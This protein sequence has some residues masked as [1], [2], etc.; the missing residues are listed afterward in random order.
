MEGG[1]LTEK[2]WGVV[3]MTLAEWAM[4]GA[5][6]SATIRPISS[7][8]TCPGFG[9]CLMGV[10]AMLDLPFKALVDTRMFTK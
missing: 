5:L 4:P 7:I 6:L 3:R 10:I 8:A 2:D 1:L 9:F